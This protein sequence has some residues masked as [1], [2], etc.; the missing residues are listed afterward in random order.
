MCW[1]AGGEPVVT[2][3]GGGLGGRCQE[4]ALAAALALEGHPGVTVLA[5]GTD[6]SDGPTD[7]AGALADGDTLSRGRAAGRDPQQDLAEN[8]SHHFFREEGGLIRTGPTG[9]NVNDLF[10]AGTSKRSR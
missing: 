9:S 7:A 1:I 6:G 5:A 10:F 3:R 2:V 4:F 8:D